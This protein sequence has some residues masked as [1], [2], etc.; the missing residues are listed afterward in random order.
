VETRVIKAERAHFAR[1]QA[2]RKVA[3]RRA[4][5]GRLLV[6]VEPQVRKAVPAWAKVEPRS[7]K[8]AR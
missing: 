8:A 5:L 7:H 1:V 3:T 6:S 4:R 2:K